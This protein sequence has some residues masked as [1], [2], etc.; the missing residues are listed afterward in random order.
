M[1]MKVTSLNEKA[2]LVKLTMRKA[3]LTRRDSGVEA[4]V[5]SQF[6]DSSL[7]VLCRL[8][9][10]KANPINQVMTA[11]SEIYTYHK[12]H[13][14]PYVDKG[15]RILPNA[16]YM[17]YTSEMRQRIA[18]VDNLLAK[19][20]P[21]YDAY[22]QLD[23]AYRSKGAGRA[24]VED[25]PTA[26]EFQSRMGFDLRFMPLPDQKHFLFDLSDEDVD[27]FTQA[28]RDVEVA[29]RNDALTRMLE[30]LGHLVDKLNRP[31]GTDGAI[32]R[33]SAVENVVEGLEIARK[34][35]IDANPEL[36]SII[37][38]LDA[39]VSKYADHKEWL[40]ESPIVREQAAKQ[41]DDIA[42]Q[43]GAFMGG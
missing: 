25:Y 11:T 42:K 15:P 7:T 6:D 40:R 3:N 10:D 27:N 31:I 37:K 21:N 22:V 17:D 38:Q 39:A 23:I 14:L 1:D 32:F 20:M 9:K 13:T 16:L 5:Q 2:M 12:K 19:F 24:K 36:E 18:H 28:M 8:F 29:A 4:I 35:M 30:P 33:D 43:M 34:L 41:L 26:V